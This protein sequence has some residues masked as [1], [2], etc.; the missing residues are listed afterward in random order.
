MLTEDDG[1]GGKDLE[2]WMKLLLP[3]QRSIGCSSSRTYV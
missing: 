3:S 2:V 1:V